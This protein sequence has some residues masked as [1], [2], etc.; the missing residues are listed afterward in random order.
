MYHTTTFLSVW[1]VVDWKSMLISKEISS[2]NSFGKTAAHSSSL[3]MEWWGKLCFTHDEAD[4]TISF[5]VSDLEV[6]YCSCH[7][8]RC[9]R[10]NMKFFMH[11]SWE[12]YCENLWDPW[13]HSVLSMSLFMRTRVNSILVVK[14]S[15]IHSFCLTPS[16]WIWLEWWQDLQTSIDCYGWTRCPCA[17]RAF[18]LQA[19]W[20]GTHLFWGPTWDQ[21]C[22]FWIVCPHLGPSP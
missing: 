5:A 19:L 12:W 4:L 3:E 7:L 22:T 2:F 13:C 1:K 14:E 11:C 16:I 6:Q 17:W 9:I 18:P 10:K 20:T 8:G 21:G 15:S